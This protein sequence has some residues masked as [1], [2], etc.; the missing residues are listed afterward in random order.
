MRSRS[1]RNDLNGLDRGGLVIGMSRD[2]R[3]TYYTPADTHS[4]II[5][6]TRSGKTRNLVLPSIG[7]TAM[8]GESMILVDMKGELY[9]DTR[10]FLQAQGYEIIAIDFTQPQ[11]SNRYNFLQPTVDALNRGNVAKAVTATRDMA[12]MLVVQ[13]SWH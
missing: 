3:Q 12:T 9:S 4:L 13:K 2:G 1:R 7:L 10:Y 11:Y 6:A 5:G 8:A